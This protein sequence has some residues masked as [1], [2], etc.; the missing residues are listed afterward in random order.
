MASANCEWGNRD[1]ST[2]ECQYGVC[3]LLRDTKRGDEIVAALNLLN[4]YDGDAKAEAGVKSTSAHGEQRHAFLS[5]RGRLQ[6]YL[7]WSRSKL[8]DHMRRIVRFRRH[9]GRT[10]R[11][12]EV[13]DVDSLLD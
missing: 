12:N 10:G 3:I 9:E 1:T 13:P 7:R 6:K 8:K 2:N 5:L 4:K 11:W